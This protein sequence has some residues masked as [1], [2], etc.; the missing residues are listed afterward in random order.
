MKSIGALV[1][2]IMIGNLSANQE[3][4]LSGKSVKR[5]HM[6][7]RSGGSYNNIGLDGIYFTSVATLLGEAVEPLITRPDGGLPSLSE[8]RI[9][10]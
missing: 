9:L 1:A 4:V 10:T 5:D 8:F 2:E 3:P 6:L 7:I